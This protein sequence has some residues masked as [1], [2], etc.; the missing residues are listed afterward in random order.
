V[1]TRRRATPN[2]S[3]EVV[4][5]VRILAYQKSYQLLGETIGFQARVCPTGLGCTAG[6]R[7]AIASIAPDRRRNVQKPRQGRARIRYAGK[8]AIPIRQS[9]PGRIRVRIA[10]LFPSTS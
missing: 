2:K 6:Y 7:G 4:A 9:A 5:S 3:F 1:T 10:R 8:R